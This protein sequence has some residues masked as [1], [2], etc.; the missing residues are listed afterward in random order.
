MSG[1]HRPAARGDQTQEH[2]MPVNSL[3]DLFLVKLQMIYDAEQQGL[4]AMPLMAQRVS[5]PELRQGLEMHRAQ[6]EQQVQR[7]EQLFQLEG[8]SPKARECTSFRA[9]VS[10][11]QTQ[12]SE[13]QDP[14]TL[15][16]FIIAAQQAAEHHEIAAYGTARSWAQELGRSEAAQ[17][18]EQTLNEEKQADQLLT[19]MAERRVNQ[20]ASE[21]VSM[22]D[23]DVTRSAMRADAPAGGTL[24]S[25]TR[26]GGMSDSLDADA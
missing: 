18:L 3:H 10:E 25:S 22:S 13:I 26:R 20:E 11:A 19:E 15:D 9:L 14:T 24:G 12:M 5:N 21:G 1:E 7:L 17:L 4:Q 2:A 23:R 8:M 16:A 6:T